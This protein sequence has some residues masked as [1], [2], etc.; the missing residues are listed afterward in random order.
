MAKRKTLA[1]LVEF[2]TQVMAVVTKFYRGKGFS[3]VYDNRE[4][5]FIISVNEREKTLV[6]AFVCCKDGGEEFPYGI[7]DRELCERT[8]AK[9]LDY[10]NRFDSDDYWVRFD[11]VSVLV[12]G[13]IAYIRAARDYFGAEWKRP[14]AHESSESLAE[15]QRRI[16]ELEAEAEE[17]E[18][19][20]KMLR[21]LLANKA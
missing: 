20:E 4:G 1:E 6:V 14:S 17:A 13:N 12:C 15:M 9:F 7:L 16:A 2:E 3:P 5:M 19:R 10:D 11:Q 8:L 18:Q 21:R